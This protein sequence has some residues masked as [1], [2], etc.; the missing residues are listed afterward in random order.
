MESVKILSDF[1]GFYAGSHLIQAIMSTQHSPVLKKA[2]E[3]AG[4]KSE[5]KVQEDSPAA[6][7]LCSIYEKK[8]KS[9]PQGDLGLVKDSWLKAEAIH[10]LTMMHLSQH[11]F[12]S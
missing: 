1:G 11:L 8:M 9:L 6:K 7:R 3:K 5:D 10:I 12:R 2:E 4:V